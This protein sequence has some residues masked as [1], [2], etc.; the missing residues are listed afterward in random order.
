MIRVWTWYISQYAHILQDIGQDKIPFK[1]IY[2]SSH[3]E[4]EQCPPCSLSTAGCRTAM[5]LM[6]Y[7]VT[8]ANCSHIHCER[9][10]VVL[11]LGANSRPK[12]RL[13]TNQCHRT[14]QSKQVYETLYGAQQEEGCV[15]PKGSEEWCL[16][17]DTYS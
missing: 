6:V 8:F 13:Q 3:E 5:M 14:D 1:N 10:R 15:I 2:Q 12:A 16:L 11:L 9:R 4:I 17:L 7:N